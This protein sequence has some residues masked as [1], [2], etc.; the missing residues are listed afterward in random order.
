LQTTGR[1]LTRHSRRP[2]GTTRA[3][4]IGTGDAEAAN[5]LCVLRAGVAR[6]AALL[7]P[8]WLPIVAARAMLA[9]EFNGTKRLRDYVKAAANRTH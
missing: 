7:G 4:S 5:R 2:A 3:K 8:R 1:S 9:G 6:L